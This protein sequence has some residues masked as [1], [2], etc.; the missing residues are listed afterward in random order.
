M[1]AVYNYSG[2]VDIV[3]SLSKQTRVSVRVAGGDSHQP[4]AGTSQARDS[5]YPPG[6]A[7]PA[8]KR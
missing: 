2:F 1:H 3:E 5:G 4:S 7:P 6:S 8:D